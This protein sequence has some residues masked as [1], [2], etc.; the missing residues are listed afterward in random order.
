MRQRQSICST[1]LGAR[2][3]HRHALYH[4]LISAALITG[5]RTSLYIE[6]LDAVR[7]HPIFDV[8][9][10]RV[11]VQTWC[12]SDRKLRLLCSPTLMANMASYT[13]REVRKHRSKKD[14]WVVSEGHVY[15]VGDFVHKHPGGTDI[16][17]GQAG[18]DIT[19]VMQDV[20]S[21]HH[22]KAAYQILEKYRIG[23]LKTAA[24]AKKAKSKKV[25]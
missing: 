13:H 21:H 8:T 6:H 22:S 3:A 10:V 19:D 4:Y 7:L 18:Q 15:D 5:R 23:D 17:L 16:L 14:L 24:K 1:T 9:S 12:L 11:A 25:C 20:Q 2:R